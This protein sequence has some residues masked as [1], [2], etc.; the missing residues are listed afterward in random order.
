MRIGVSGAH[1]TG[2]TTLIEG[3]CAHLPDHVPVDEPYLLLEEEGYEFSYPPSPEDYRAQLKRSVLLLHSP[4]DDIIF[5]RTPVDFLA[6]LA[7]QGHD[8]AEEAAPY[9]LESVMTGLDILVVA[10]ITAE[11]EKSLPKAEMPRLRESVNDELLDILHADPLHAWG[12]LPILE[13]TVPLDRRIDVTLAAMS[14]A[15]QS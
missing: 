6:Y 4:A 10:P 13:L 15:G 9:A 7:V 11:T 14:R 5:D 12:E 1:G 3:L 2:K 8:I